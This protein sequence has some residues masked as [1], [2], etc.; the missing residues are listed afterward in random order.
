MSYSPTPIVQTISI[1]NSLSTQLS[2]LEQ[3]TDLVESYTRMANLIST[4]SY[5]G[6]SHFL[7]PTLAHCS[8]WEAAVQTLRDFRQILDD[9]GTTSASMPATRR[10]EIICAET[11]EEF[12]EKLASLAPKQ[13]GCNFGSLKLY[14]DWKYR[15]RVTPYES[16]AGGYT[17]PQ[18]L[19]DWERDQLSAKLS[20]R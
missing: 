3:C 2:E 14:A 12:F 8:S 5:S 10:G 9:A 4:V 16:P 6:L 20:G 11:E 1:L 15:P 18:P 13:L 19:Q 17:V 7:T